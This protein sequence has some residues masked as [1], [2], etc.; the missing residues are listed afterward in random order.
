MSE[1]Q[2]LN[3]AIETDKHCKHLKA[4]SI[5]QKDILNYFECDKRFYVSYYNDIE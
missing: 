5:W 3:L 2:N 4:K 1:N